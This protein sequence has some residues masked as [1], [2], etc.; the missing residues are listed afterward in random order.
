MANDFSVGK[1]KVSLAKG[2]EDEVVVE[3]ELNG[4]RVV[5]KVQVADFMAFLRSMYES[6]KGFKV[7][8][9]LRP[10]KY[11][12]AKTVETLRGIG[13]KDFEYIARDMQ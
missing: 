6:L 4:E 11:F 8:N 13:I 1:I 2:S 7:E 10:E 5:D 3:Y 12:D 9:K